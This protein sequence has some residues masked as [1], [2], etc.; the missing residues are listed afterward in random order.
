MNELEM[1]I[2]QTEYNVGE[3]MLSCLDKADMM[4]EYVGYSND[5]LDEYVS[6]M[7]ELFMEATARRKKADEI[8]AYMRKR[9]LGDVNS[10]NPNK[11]KTARSMR[12]F[13]IMHDF[14]PSTGTV[15]STDGKRRIRLTFNADGS[16]HRGNSF[17]GYDEIALEKDIKKFHQA[18]KHFTI[19][20]EKGHEHFAHDDSSKKWTDQ[21][22]ENE[23]GI[24]HIKAAKEAGKKISSHDDGSYLTKDE[25]D[26]PEELEADLH[27]VKNTRIRTKYAGRKRAVKRSGATRSINDNE[28]EKVFVTMD[29]LASKPTIPESEFK[30]YRDM[31]SC[32]IKIRDAYSLVC[33]NLRSGQATPKNCEGIRTLRDKID[34]FSWYLNNVQHKRISDIVDDYYRSLNFI[35]EILDEIKRIKS[36]TELSELDER[37]LSNINDLLEEYREKVNNIKEHHKDIEKSG[38][39]RIIKIRHDISYLSST[40]KRDETKYNE[41]LTKFLNDETNNKQLMNELI[42]MLTEL[43][44]PEIIR[45]NFKDDLKDWKKNMLKHKM[46]DSTQMRHDFVKKYVHECFEE[47]MMDY[48]SYE[49]VFGDYMEE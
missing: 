48:Y 49:N 43:T 8:D 39:A 14:D 20:H 24:K 21:L 1:L 44:D 41:L 15:K 2:Q 7:F 47:F 31:C 10:K 17:G 4:L 6:E 19:N 9:N 25:H 36:K 30:N 22:D 23:R 12:N 11:A 42:D 35:D 29:K 18:D 33:K 3:A 34:N 38:G 26:S 28:I 32:L 16:F 40:L 37:T 46:S 5:A 27:G 13:L 45:K